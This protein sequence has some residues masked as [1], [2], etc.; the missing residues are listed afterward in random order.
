MVLC[1][2]DTDN[3]E[4]AVKSREQ[5]KQLL[6]GESYCLITKNTPDVKVKLKVVEFW[7][8]IKDKI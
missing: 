3:S 6:S 7:S 1:Y 4:A 5:L 2:A 8:E